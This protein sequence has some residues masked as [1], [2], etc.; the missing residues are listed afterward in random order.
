[1]AGKEVS[2]I[3]KIV[4]LGDSG[5]GK[6]SLVQ[7]YVYDSMEPDLGRT[8]GA[9]LHV[10]MVEY[11]GLLHKLVIWDIGGQESF[12]QLREQFCANSSGAFFVFDR[13]RPE[14]L[15]HIDE[16]LNALKASTKSAVVLAIENKI[17]LESCI[18]DDQVRTLI[19]TRGL[20]LIPTSAVENT[21]VDKA[22]LAMV[23]SIRAQKV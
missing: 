11:E 10:K 20:T 16:W 21:N 5:V 23:K 1:M 7:R 3:Y 4:F 6:T 15:M 9:V 12:A 22:F 18:T 2:F 17:D 8:I 13:T 19:E 14:T